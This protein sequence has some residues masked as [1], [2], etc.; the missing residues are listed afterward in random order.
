[1]LMF[2]D[3]KVSPWYCLPSSPCRRVS[4]YFARASS[5]IADATRK[6]RSLFQAAASP[7]DCGKTV[8]IPA[9]PTPWMHS[10]HQL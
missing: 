10:F 6:S 2:G 3:Q 4:W 7:I 5:A 8:A 9:R 1:M